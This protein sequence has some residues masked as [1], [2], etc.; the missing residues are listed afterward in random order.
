MSAVLIV[1]SVPK[2]YLQRPLKDKAPLQVRDLM[3]FIEAQ[4]VVQ[5][6]GGADSEL[7]NG[8][9]LPMPEQ[10]PEQQQRGKRRTQRTALR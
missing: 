10:Q 7:S 6:S 4:R 2:V 1:H 8:T 3:M 9:V 5:A